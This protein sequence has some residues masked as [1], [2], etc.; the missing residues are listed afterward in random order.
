MDIKEIKSKQKQINTYVLSGKIA[1][2]LPLL[3]ELVYISQDGDSIAAL[4]NLEITYKNILKY[5]FGAAKDPE[6]ER[7]YNNLR[8]QLIELS[9]KAVYQSTFKNSAWIERLRK[10][11]EAYLRLTEV[12]KT[13]LIDELAS[14]KEFTTLLN[15]IDPE[16]TKNSESIEKYNNTLGKLFN[17]L[18]IEGKYSEG[19][20][21]FV[22]QLLNAPSIPWHD[23]SLIIS[24]TTLSLFNYFDV[25]KLDLLFDIY[26]KGEEQLAQRALVGVIFSL[27]VYKNRL[28]LYPEVIHRI[29]T[30]EDTKALAKQTEQILI[31]LIKAQETEKVTEKIQKE[32][33]PEVMKMKPD[34][35]EKLRLEDLLNKDEFEDKNPDWENF[36]GESS[37]V[38]KKMEEF[39]MMQMDGSDVFM[40]AF[41]MLKRFGF[42]DKLSNWFLPFF[43]EHPEVSKSISDVDKKFDWNTFFEGIEQAPVM[44]N[45]DKYSFC[46]NIGFMPDMQKSMMLEMFSMELKQMKELAEDENK[47]DAS[48]KNRIVFT[49]YIQDLYRFFKL[50]PKK[51]SFN[52]VFNVNL[53]ITDTSFL[54]EIFVQSDSIRKIGE[55]YFN[56]NYF[57]SALEIFEKLNEKEQSYELM[58]KM[59]FCYQKLEQYS[60]A[61]EKYKEAEI[62][63]NN[64]IWLH[65]KIGYCYRKL[66]KY[67]LAIE[68]YSKVETHEPENLEVQAYLGQ[69]HIDKEDYEEALRYYFKVEYLK[70]NFSKVQRPIAWCSFL[71]KKPD[72]ATRYFEKVV[73]SDGQRSDF[74]NLAHSY[75]V[76]ENVAGAIDNY[77]LALKHSGNDKKW[78]RNSLEEDS[79]HIISYG[80]D[81]LEIGLMTDYIL[82]E[83]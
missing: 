52:D 15:D 53:N 1:A 31:Q 7:I 23:K 30:F 14:E 20:K 42:F 62:F 37:E 73:A 49:Q 64:R 32:I 68:Y 11:D 61:I 2:A 66:N 81:A 8:R 4:E 33:I 50:H 43:K 21:L 58:E 41:S 57:V 3:S 80:I 65:K 12:E 9:D 6:R 75:W 18:W 35:E 60:K 44:C 63:E 77:R 24:A 54:N 79:K 34:I 72:Q 45:S 16:A 28:S 69:L 59:G 46:F 67:D 22:Q 47:H 38:Y 5:S 39:S 82:L 48:G 29:K 74:L 70:P 27:L 36:F 55:F 83:V 10:E 13:N 26:Q 71:L 25:S 17:L 76:N 19:D 51:E 40:G 56:K 78:F